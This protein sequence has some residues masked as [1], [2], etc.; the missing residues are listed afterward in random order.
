MAELSFQDNAWT[1][2]RTTYGGTL[3]VAEQSDQWMLFNIQRCI[4]CGMLRTMVIQHCLVNSWKLVSC[5]LIFRHKLVQTWSEPLHLF[6]LPQYTAHGVHITFTSLPH[7]A[8][9]S[10][11]NFLQHCS[12]PTQPESP[13]REP[14]NYCYCR[15]TKEAQSRFS[16]GF[17]QEDWCNSANT[18][19]A[20]PGRPVLNVP[21]SS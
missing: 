16:E 7:H 19:L 15:N 10:L 6:G 3:N 11:A 13:F 17:P 1:I 2:F 9:H 20:G 14:N 12:L 5:S 4:A 8:T 21:N 18:T